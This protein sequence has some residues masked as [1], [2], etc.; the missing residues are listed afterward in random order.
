MAMEKIHP[1]S[2]RF[3]SPGAEC[4]QAD[5]PGQRQVKGGKCINLA[6]AKMH[7]EGGRRH[8]KA[9]ETRPGNGVIAI[10]K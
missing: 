5:E 7:C 10:K 9:V 8:Q 3:Q 1:T 6:D 2:F 4:G